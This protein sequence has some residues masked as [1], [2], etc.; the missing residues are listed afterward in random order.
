MRD[1]EEKIAGEIAL[2]EDFGKPI[3]FLGTGQKLE[4]LKP[5]DPNEIISGIFP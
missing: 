1:I 3:L 2:S 5:Y 4:D